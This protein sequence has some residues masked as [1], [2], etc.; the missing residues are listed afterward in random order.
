M[1]QIDLQSSSV[2]FTAF[3]EYLKYAYKCFMN[4]HCY[5]TLMNVKVTPLNQQA[6]YLFFKKKKKKGAAP[7][8]PHHSSTHSE[9]DM[10]SQDKV[11][12]HSGSSV[13][14][15]CISNDATEPVKYV[16]SEIG[17]EMRC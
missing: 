10:R 8:P 13:L 12:S 7:L 14:N 6:L 17:D 9:L 15:L 11:W 2:H 16:H 4:D 5:K 1:T 3:A